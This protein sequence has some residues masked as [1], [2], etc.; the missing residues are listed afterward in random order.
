MKEVRNALFAETAPAAQG[1]VAAQQLLEEVRTERERRTAEKHYLEVETRAF[2]RRE[3]R[4]E[5]Q[6]KKLQ[7]EIEAQ[8][9]S[10]LS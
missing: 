5:E 8:K 1:Q 2:L 6:I 3:R 4:W 7:S 10:F 9:G